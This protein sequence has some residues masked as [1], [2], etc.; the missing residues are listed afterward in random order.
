MKISHLF[1]FAL[2]LLAQVSFAQG[3]IDTE[4]GLLDIIISLII[5]LIVGGVIGYMM[6]SRKSSK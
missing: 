4:G 3:V 2:V 5:G 1:A 6:G